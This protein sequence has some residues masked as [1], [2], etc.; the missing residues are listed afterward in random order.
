MKLNAIIVEDEQIS[1]DILKNYIAK[2]CKDV[3]VLNEATNVDEAFKILEHTEVDL[4][5]LDVE[6]PFGTAFDLLDKLPNR[7]FETVFVTAYDQYAKDALNQQAAYYLTK[8]IDIDELIK[9]VEIVQAIKT[10]ESE[11][12]V[13]LSIKEENSSQLTD[14]ITI[15]T[16]EGFEVLPIKDIIYCSADDNYTHIYLE[17]AT[18]LVSKTLKHFDDM[19]SDKGFAR[20]HKSHLINVSHVTAYKKGKGGSV[21]LG[22]VELPV[23]PS[24]KLGLFEYF[25]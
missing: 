16:Q 20:I 7:T 6:M 19:L 23:S 12:N 14:K 9:A 2:Y 1:R 21:L 18:K 8:P 17:N 3:S 15:P 5:F 22:K 25:S 11:V 24:K 10:R 4:V 13:D